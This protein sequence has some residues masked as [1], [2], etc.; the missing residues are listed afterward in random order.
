MFEHEDEHR[1]A[2]DRE[3]I[4]Y[5]YLDIDWEPTED[6]AALAEVALSRG[7]GPEYFAPLVQH[8]C[9]KMAGYHV[10]GAPD[11]PADDAEFDLYYERVCAE[12]ERL[13]DD[14][15]AN[16][17]AEQIA[18]LE[19]YGDVELDDLRAGIDP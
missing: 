14:I 3:Y 11:A 1:D 6:A 5:E 15:N 10:Q 18:F 12:A 17:L 7:L 8:Y 9:W 19:M 4:G 2:R 13:A 16:G